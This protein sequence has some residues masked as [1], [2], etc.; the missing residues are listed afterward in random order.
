M[1]DPTETD[2]L[3]ADAADLGVAGPLPTVQRVGT[4]VDGR[5]VS[6]LRWGARPGV[7]LLHGAGLNAHTWDATLLAL[8]EDALAV[9]LPGHGDSAWRDDFDYRPATNATAVAALLDALGTG[10][11]VVV[12]QSLGG[13]TAIALAADRPDLVAALVIVDASPGLRV[14][15]AKQVTDFLAGEQVFDSREQIVA[16][17]IAAGIGADRARITRG[18]AHNTRVRDDGK[19]VWKHH[20]AYPPKA[21]PGLPDVTTP[22]TGLTATEVPVLLV[23]AA[24]GYLPDDVVAEFRERVPRAAVVELDTGHNVQEQDPAGLAAAIRGVLG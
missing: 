2:S 24:H 10:P 22:W 16:N 18:V 14:G 15:D 9:D 6:A 17:A 4:E 7:T 19:V 12:G 20:L 3:A 21:A 23:R 1:S 8:H 11:Q 5:L 13:L